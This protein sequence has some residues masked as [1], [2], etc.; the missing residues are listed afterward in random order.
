MSIEEIRGEINNV[1]E[2]IIRLFEQRM[3]LV[4]KIGMYKKEHSLPIRDR[5]RER[6]IVRRLCEEV[7]PELAEYTKSLYS[8]LFEMSARYQATLNLN[9]SAVD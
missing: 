4:K 1:D 3:D 2:G 7:H 6:E 8:L 9:D 5:K